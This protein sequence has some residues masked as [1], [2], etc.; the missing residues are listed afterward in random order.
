MWPRFF[1]R[2]VMRFWPIRVQPTLSFPAFLISE[3]CFGPLGQT[4]ISKTVSWDNE[5]E[6]WEYICFCVCCL[7]GEVLFWSLFVL[8]FDL[9]FVILGRW[10]FFFFAVDWL[11]LV[12]KVTES[13]VK[14]EGRWRTLVWKVVCSSTVMKIWRRICIK[15]RLMETIRIIRMTPMK[16]IQWGN[17]AATAW[18]GL[19]VTG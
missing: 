6:V 10:V 17:P 2:K 3:F 5:S 19:K 15:T 12:G 13:V 1:I 8:W 16:T 14:I 11:V 9:C 7:L 4:Q 18:H